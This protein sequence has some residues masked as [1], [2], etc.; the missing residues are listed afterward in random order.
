M[1]TAAYLKITS[2]ET[3]HRGSIVDQQLNNEV[4]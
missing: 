4:A 1:N 3:P 2:A